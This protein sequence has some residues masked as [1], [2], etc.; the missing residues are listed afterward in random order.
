M[1]G[2]DPD[3]PRADPKK[4]SRWKSAAKAAG[5]ELSS[6]GTEMMNESRSDSAS[7]IGPVS[8]K[9]GGR[10]KKTGLA[11]LHKGEVVVPRNKVRKYKKAMRR[12]G[13]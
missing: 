12:N 2:P 6:Y 9:K 4:P 5:S 10:V 1:P 7:R 13:R 11:R 3:G 8:Y